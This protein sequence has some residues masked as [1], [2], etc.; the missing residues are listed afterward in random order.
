MNGTDTLSDTQ[1]AIVAFVQSYRQAHEYGPSVR[2]V[3]AGVG[4]R[5]TATVQFHLLRLCNRGVLAAE[6]SRART[7]RVTE[8]GAAL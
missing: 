4:L 6:P 1:R 2:E 3:A 8:K 5:S 7:L